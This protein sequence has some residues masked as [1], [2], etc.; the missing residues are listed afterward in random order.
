MGWGAITEGKDLSAD[1]RINGGGGWRMLLLNGDN[2]SIL[3]M[4]NI[5]GSVLLAASPAFSQ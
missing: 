4:G 2:P 3:S 5:N 1:E